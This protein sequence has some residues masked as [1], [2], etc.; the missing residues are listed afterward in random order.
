MRKRT[1]SK[2]KRSRRLVLAVWVAAPALTHRTD[3]FAWAAL[4]VITIVLLTGVLV[5]LV[6]VFAASQRRRNARWL[7]RV[8]LQTIGPAKGRSGAGGLVSGGRGRPR[9]RGHG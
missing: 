5:V 9:G 2:W 7:L 1:R 6:S 8:V 3:L 4:A